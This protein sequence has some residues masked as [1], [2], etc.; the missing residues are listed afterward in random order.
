MIAMPHQPKCNNP[1][2]NNVVLNHIFIHE[3]DL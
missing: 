3:P 2:E 1:N